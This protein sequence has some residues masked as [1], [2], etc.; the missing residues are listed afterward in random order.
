MRLSQTQSLQQRLSPQQV[1]FLKML[2]LPLPILEQ[3][4]SEELAENPVLE[5]ESADESAEESGA[6]P[7]DEDE[8][9][10]AEV[11]AGAEAS[12][13]GESA[14]LDG[15]VGQAADPLRDEERL[16][17]IEALPLTPTQKI[18]RGRLRDLLK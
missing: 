17:R 9:P 10:V 8:S 14:T 12:G 6:E 2:Q 3:R 15:E 4:I 16:E 1:L 13:S 5:T 7:L 18:M 11:E